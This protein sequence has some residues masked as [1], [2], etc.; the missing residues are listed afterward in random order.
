MDQ[1]SELSYPNEQVFMNI[2]ESAKH[3]LVEIIVE[4]SG[5]GIKAKD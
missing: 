4:D 3:G 5:I 2:V 1:I